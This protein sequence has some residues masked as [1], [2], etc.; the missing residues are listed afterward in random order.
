[1][2]NI[3]FLLCL[4]L[5]LAPSV[6]ADEQVENIFKKIQA[7]NPGLR[8]YQANIEI[9]LDVRLAFIPYRPEMK[10]KYYHKRPDFHKLEV[11]NAPSYVKKYPN[12]F[13]WHLP[14]LAKYNSIVE[15]EDTYQGQPVYF[16]V[17]LPN[18]Q[19]GDIQR[20]E[21]WVNRE[22]HTVPRQ[23]TYYGKNGKLD[24]M[25]DYV[26]RD[27]FLVFDKMRA[28]FDFP[29]VSVSAK[30]TAAYSG[31]MFNQGLEDSFFDSER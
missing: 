18:Q 25:V 12:I 5:V 21:M 10:G 20:I 9:K 27:G 19:V 7:I 31:Y 15:R 6:G 4:F 16:I 14:R 29:S 22:N 28:S 2:R 1:M 24:V 26:D 17:M 3:A 23:A 30:A 8:D 11:E 13:G